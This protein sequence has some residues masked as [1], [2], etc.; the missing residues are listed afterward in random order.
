MQRSIREGDIAHVHLATQEQYIQWYHEHL[1]RA[2][3]VD[4]VPED[5]RVKPVLTE[6][7]GL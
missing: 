1:D 7:L 3:G 6:A 4:R 5:L 2:I